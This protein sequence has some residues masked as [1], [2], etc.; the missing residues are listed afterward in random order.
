MK[1]II[2]TILFL[3]FAVTC[4]ADIG[5]YIVPYKRRGANKIIP[6]RYCTIDDYTK[7]I[8]S[9]GGS[10]S[11]AEVLGDRV[12]VKVKATALTLAIL[13]GIFKRIPKNILDD[14]LA[15]LPLKV[16]KALKDEILNMGYTLA[17]IQ[18]RF[19][20]DLG[21]YTLRDVLKFMATRRLKPRYDVATDTIICDGIIQPVR[22]IE[23]VDNAVK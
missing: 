21:T 18:E 20:N 6:E 11:E 4:F 14:S 13:D 23:S 19:P 12:I 10:W 16:K 9:D 22:P 15:D 8:K 5:W 3:S 2:L 7:Q 17:E 1:K